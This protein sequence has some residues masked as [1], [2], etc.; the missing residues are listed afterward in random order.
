MTH[1]CAGHPCDH[2]FLCDVVGVCC[3]TVDAARVD[4]HPD[5]ALRQAILAECRATAADL[6]DSPP[7]E[8]LRPAPPLA[9]LPPGLRAAVPAVVHHEKGTTP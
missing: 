9:R 3:Q 4:R 8:A 7:A 1:P 5:D 2:C 6:A